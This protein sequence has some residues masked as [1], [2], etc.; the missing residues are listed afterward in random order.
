MKH[1]KDASGSAEDE[2]V[3]IKAASHTFCQEPFLLL[4]S[5]KDSKQCLLICVISI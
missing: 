2:G 5:I 3:Y 4:K 1:C